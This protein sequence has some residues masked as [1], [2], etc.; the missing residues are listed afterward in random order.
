M[1][2]PCVISHGFCNKSPQTWYSTLRPLVHLPFRR[3][4]VQAASLRMPLSLPAG[5]AP[6]WRLQGRF[7]SCLSWLPETALAVAPHP[8]LKAC[9]DGGVSSSHCIPQHSLARCPS[10]PAFKALWGPWAHLGSAESCREI[11][12]SPH[13]SCYLHPLG[14]R[15][16]SQ[17]PG[18][19][20]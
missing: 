18:V 9:E 3:S 15:E 12:N 17:V 6:F 2:G 8:I 11:V 10:S 13:P 4:K 19:S 20:T 7:C 16:S 1:L 14:H 5:C